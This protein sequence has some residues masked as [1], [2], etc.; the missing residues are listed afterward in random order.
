MSQIEV[1]S[2]QQ[3]A[4]KINKLVMGFLM[5]VHFTGIYG[6]SLGTFHV[7][8]SGFSNLYLEASQGG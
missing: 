1:Q 6:A 8:D 3:T 5:T 4:K 7:A 2:L